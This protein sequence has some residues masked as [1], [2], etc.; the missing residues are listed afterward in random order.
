MERLYIHITP[1]TKTQEI[2][3]KWEI[4]TSSLSVDQRF[5]W[6]KFYGNFWK[7]TLPV[8]AFLYDALKSQEGKRQRNLPWVNNEVKSVFAWRKL[9]IIPYFVDCFQADLYDALVFNA[10]IPDSDLIENHAVIEG[11]EN[12]IYTETAVCS[13]VKMLDPEIVDIEEV[14]EEIFGIKF[15]FVTYKFPESGDKYFEKILLS[16]QT[17]L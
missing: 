10:K 8:K 2:L 11:V 9:G 13:P 17:R 6:S 4:D 14:C 3:K 12:K 16:K 5:W 15:P 1:K 7:G